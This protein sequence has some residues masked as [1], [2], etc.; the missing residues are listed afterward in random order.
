M[1]IAQIEGTDILVAD[2]QELYPNTSFPASGPDA[3]WLAE[4]DCMMVSVWLPYDQNTQKLV[5]AS[6]YIDGDYVYTIVVEPMTPE[7]IAARE[8]SQKAQVKAQA[9]SLLTATDWTTIPDVSDPA[10][11]DP[12]LTNAAEFA[13][14][15]SDVRKIAVNP[16]VTVGT[17]PVQPEEVWAYTDA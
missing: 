3:E 6:P 5:P 11:S 4:N 10:L 15:R 9:A 17:W 7:E 8:Q 12:Y 13:A 2:Y 14:Y 16:P 1:L